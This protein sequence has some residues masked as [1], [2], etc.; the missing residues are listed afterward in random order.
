MNSGRM[1]SP[2]R[3]T[4]PNGTIAAFD[5]TVLHI[6]Q[7]IIRDLKFLNEYSYLS[8]G[9]YEVIVEKLPKSFEP[10]A[11]PH[12]P[13]DPSPTSSPA[14]HTSSPV[15]PGTPKGHYKN[16]SPQ[17]NSQEIHE[18]HPDQISL[19][20]PQLS[21]IQTSLPSQPQQIPTSSPMQSTLSQINTQFNSPI[22]NQARV[23]PQP[24][25]TTTPPKPIEPPTFASKQAEAES[26]RVE[27]EQQE[28][29]P[30][31]SSETLEILMALWDFEGGDEGDLTFRKGDIIEVIE[32]VNEDWWKGR[33][34]GKSEIGIFP[35][36][37]AEPLSNRISM[38]N[39]NGHQLRQQSQHEAVILPQTTTVT[40]IPSQ[41][42]QGGQQYPYST[43]QQAGASPNNINPYQL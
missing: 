20:Q 19:Q 24:P 11:A 17:R 31:Y 5:P 3:S 18:G 23:L 6:I 42:P 41:Q 33:I 21:R 7:G 36:T 37:Y 30:M 32:H 2:T 1:G 14:L 28:D 29:L 43:S 35:K 38:S 15:I 27:Q 12:T 26:Y 4:K 9:D 25:G 39:N 13:P 40:I 22:E 34:Q 10:H 16:S 8:N